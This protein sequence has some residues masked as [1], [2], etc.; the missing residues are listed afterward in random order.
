MVLN[1]EVSKINVA[2]TLIILMHEIIDTN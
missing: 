1:S 2:S